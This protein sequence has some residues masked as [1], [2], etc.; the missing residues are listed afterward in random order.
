[1][2]GVYFVAGTD[3]GVGKTLV[4]EALILAAA[5]AGYSAA[6]I[7]PVAAGGE[8]TVDGIRNEDAM[9]LGRT[10][11]VALNYQ[12]LNPCVLKEPLAPHIAAAR[13]GRLLSAQELAGACQ[14]ALEKQADFTFVEGAGGW[15]VPL[16]DSETMADMV[17]A[18][19]IPVIL[20]VGMRLGC[21][22]HALLTAEAIAADGLPMAGWVANC[23]DPEMA[24]YREN[25]EALRA[26]LTAPLIAEIPYL[27]ETDTAAVV[28]R[29]NLDR[30]RPASS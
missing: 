7:K 27:V 19:Q 14:P 25:L 28:S 18:L 17:C 9:I 21:L 24:A 15:R 16:N 3:T 23:I 13:E 2:S 4:C 29:I 26:R 5:K 11:N 30:L 12:E 1:M 8:V 10:V 22:N 6:A 20:V